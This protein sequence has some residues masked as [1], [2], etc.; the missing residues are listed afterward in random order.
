MSITCTG[1]TPNSVANHILA[2]DGPAGAGKS[3]LAARMAARFGL[4]NLETG[5]M[6]RAFGLKAL[7]AGVP[8]DDSAALARLSGQTRVELVP[9][10]HGSRVLLDGL[11][12]S[13]E[14]RTPEV[15]DAASR[16]SVHAPVRTWMVALQQALG[17]SV[18]GGIVMEGRDI[19]TVVFP[20]ASLKIFL[21]A[22]PEA[23]T[24]R[25]LA[26][27]GDAERDAKAVLEALRARDERDRSRAESP[28]RAAED[29]V[30][31]DSTAL[32]LDAVTERVAALIQERWP[33][34][35]GGAGAAPAR[36]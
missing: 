28:L 11:D 35:R 5:A 30:V 25:R 23:R 15:S 13:G 31:L 26:Q 32:S 16:V 24:E 4:L 8:L 27:T 9:G 10:E 7:R 2:I 14:V 20:E 18:A 19:G 17:R 6:Y 29:A 22:S 1:R 3:T 34:T 21:F 33:I 36:R 12:V